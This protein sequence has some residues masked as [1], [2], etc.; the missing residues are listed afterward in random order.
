MFFTIHLFPNCLMGIVEWP[1]P[2]SDSCV[3]NHCFYSVIY[4]PRD[5]SVAKLY[6]DL[7]MFPGS[8]NSC[9]VVFLQLICHVVSFPASLE[10]L[11]AVV[12]SSWAVKFNE[13]GARRK[14]VTYFCHQG[15]GFNRSH[16]LPKWKRGCLSSWTWATSGADWAAVWTGCSG[17]I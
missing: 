7:H 9:C 15:L 1:N 13:T 4:C 16:F 17:T 5:L 8:T 6:I 10:T 14:K 2:A 11:S 3:M 12:L